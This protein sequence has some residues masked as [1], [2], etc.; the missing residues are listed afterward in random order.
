MGKRSET[1]IITAA[2]PAALELREHLVFHLAQL[3]FVQCRVG[4]HSIERI[5]ASTL[6]SRALHAG[7]P[8]HL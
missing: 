7:S 8:I 4:R 6:L 1:G 3:P 5:N 2:I